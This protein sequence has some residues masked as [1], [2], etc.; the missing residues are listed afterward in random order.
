MSGLGLW[1]ASALLTLQMICHLFAWLISHGWK[2]CWLICCERKI[3]FIGWK[4]T[5]YKPSEEGNDVDSVL[6]TQLCSA[7]SSWWAVTVLS[8]FFFSFYKELVSGCQCWTIACAKLLPRVGLQQLWWLVSVISS[9]ASRL[10]TNPGQLSAKPVD[11]MYVS[12]KFSLYR[13]RGKLFCSLKSTA[14][15]VPH[16]RTLFYKTS[17]QWS[18]LP[19]WFSLK[20]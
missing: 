3:L 11:R 16:N 9:M 8:F 12:L 2:Y 18:G 7:L 15:V 17:V 19:S 14:E 1:T 10:I 20:K 5:A 6:S 4:S 13:L